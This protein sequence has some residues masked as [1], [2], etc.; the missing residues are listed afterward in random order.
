MIAIVIVSAGIVVINLLSL[1]LV[2]VAVHFG[3]GFWSICRTRTSVIVCWQLWSK[4]PTDPQLP[5][6]HCPI[7]P[8]CLVT[9]TQHPTPNH[10]PLP[11]WPFSAAFPLG[12][13]PFAPT[14]GHFPEKSDANYALDIWRGRGPA[15]DATRLS[16]STYNKL[17]H[18]PLT[19]KWPGG[20]PVLRQLGRVLS[21]I[22]CVSRFIL[23]PW[24]S[25]NKVLYT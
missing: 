22:R 14:F 23:T 2:V 13:A 6:V 11:F 8:L 3:R 16:L 4:G 1:A 18:N 10:T 5:S 17:L 9:S 20:W 12:V 25:R 21:A 24:W 7:F 15:H 19:P